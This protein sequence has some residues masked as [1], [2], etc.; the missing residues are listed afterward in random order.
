[1]ASERVTV[2]LPAGVVREI[3]RQ[4][5]NRSKFVV[6]AVRRELDRRRRRKLLRSLAN[7]HPDSQE[8]AEAGLDD[9]VC[10]LSEEETAGL[11]DPDE[12]TAVRWSP[13]QGWSEERE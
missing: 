3:D 12:G 1:M 8:L 13:D 9:W 10:Y 6:E 4:E 7:P 5:S 11:V 2:T